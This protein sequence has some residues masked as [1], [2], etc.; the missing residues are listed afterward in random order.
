MGDNLAWSSAC[1]KWCAMSAV[2]WPHTRTD[3]NQQGGIGSGDVDEK[4]CT[5]T[6]SH[7]AL[8]DA[9]AIKAL[10]AATGQ[11]G[12]RSRVTSKMHKGMA[13]LH[14]ATSVVLSKWYQTRLFFLRLTEIYMGQPPGDT[15]RQQSHV[16]SCHRDE[17]KR[18][19]SR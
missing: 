5:C 6:T 7:Q 19:M 15:Y 1:L 11:K 13:Y 14:S 9:Q 12:R 4:S 16:E 18:G 8:A 2:P 17:E 3:G 10:V